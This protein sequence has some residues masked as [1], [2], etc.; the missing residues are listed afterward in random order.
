MARLQRNFL[1]LQS[2]GPA[3]SCG[4]ETGLRS[5]CSSQALGKKHPCAGLA[6]RKEGIA[7]RAVGSTRPQSFHRI[8]GLFPSFNLFDSLFGWGELGLCHSAR[9]WWTWSS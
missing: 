3:H 5:L 1:S 4:P 7:G 2:A 8:F 9:G 6:K